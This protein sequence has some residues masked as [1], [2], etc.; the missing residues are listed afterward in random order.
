ME[1]SYAT[2][3]GF[4]Q[5]VLRH[6]DCPRDLATQLGDVLQKARAPYR[7]LDSTTIIPVACDEE[8]RTLLRAFADLKQEQ[9]HGALSH[10]RSAGSN[11]TAEDYAATIRDSIHAVQSV[12][13]VIA[14]SSDL[15]RGL[16]K[17]GRAAPIH[18]AF[19]QGLRSFYGY[20]SDE[21]GIRHSL[22]D[23]KEAPVDEADAMFM[24]GACAAFVS[25]LINKARNAGFLDRES[26]DEVA[27]HVDGRNECGHDG[28]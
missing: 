5:F 11:L 1:G 7:V 17:L 13:Y 15:E 20:T 23:Q 24:L 10:L 9:L 16:N 26:I 19:K 12:V 4:I 25:Y 3:F 8:A 14:G 18:G 27:K 21:R 28:A 2:V 6:P 22:L